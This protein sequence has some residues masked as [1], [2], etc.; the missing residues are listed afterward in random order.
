MGLPVLSCHM[1]NLLGILGYSERGRRCVENVWEM[2]TKAEEVLAYIPE[3]RAKH[4]VQ[5]EYA[6]K[7]AGLSR[8]CNLA[9]V[10]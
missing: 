10:L 6:F 4:M 2:K 5:A 7:K 9:L 8:A 3:E 1:R